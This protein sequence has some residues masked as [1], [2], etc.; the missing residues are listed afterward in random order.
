MG[1]KYF[2]EV[3]DEAII[4]FQ[5]ATDPKEREKLCRYFILP[6]FNKLS[7]YW[8]HRLSLR[9]NDETIHD[10]VAYLYEKIPMFDES[11]KTRGFA[12]FNMIARHWFFQKLKNEKKE[13]LQDFDNI[14]EV[15]ASENDALIDDELEK[16]LES[17]EFILLFKE[18]LPK[19]RDR[20]GKEQ[21]KK[22]LDALIVLFENTDNIDIFKK[23]AIYWYLRELTGMKSK[24]IALNLS[25]IK[26]K[27]LKFKE[28]YLKGDV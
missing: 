13:V 6:A 25:K 27:F 12:Y 26:K 16:G 9:K 21:E 20:A 5:T 19:W 3:V 2:D 10:C 17:R 14:S 4:K 18:R 11:K 28:S 15:N 8:Y 23:K 7:S 24:Q 22:V 1:D